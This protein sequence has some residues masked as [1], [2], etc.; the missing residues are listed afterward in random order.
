[1]VYLEQEVTAML[2]IPVSE[3]KATL[4]ALV[5]E[6]EK[7]NDVILTRNGLPVARITAGPGRSKKPLTIEEKMQIIRNIQESA[8]GKFEPGFDSARSADFL[9]GDDGMPG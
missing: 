7:G 4:T 1:L 6:A 9:Y 3:A 2:Q 8:R 5:R